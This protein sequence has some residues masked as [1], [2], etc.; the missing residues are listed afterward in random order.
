MKKF[1][2]SVMVVAMLSVFAGVIG[3]GNSTDG[4]SQKPNDG[5]YGRMS[6]LYG[7]AGDGKSSR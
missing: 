5:E 6:P 4:D 2:S 1:L 7:P 3:C